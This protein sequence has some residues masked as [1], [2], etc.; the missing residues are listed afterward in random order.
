MTTP[1]P[2][3]LTHRETLIV[4]ARHTVPHVET[5]R[6]GF[7]DMPPVFATAMMIGFVEPEA[8]IARLLNRK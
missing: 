2:V 6:P 3:G 7:T 1:Q 8:F 4:T 5:D